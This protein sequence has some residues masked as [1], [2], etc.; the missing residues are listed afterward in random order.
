MPKLPL[1][2][3]KD[4]LKNE[5][6]ELRS[7]KTVRLLSTID[8][9]ENTKCSNVRLFTI[10][11]IEELEAVK[12]YTIEL[13]ARGFE[14]TSS[15]QI[16]PR[17]KHKLHIY[18]L[19]HYPFNHPK[20]GAPIRIIWLTPIFHPNISSGKEAGGKGIVCWRILQEWI[21]NFNLADIVIGI[22]DL[23]EKPNVDDAILLPETKEAAEWFRKHL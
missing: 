4:R 12:R 7:L 20:Y 10:N 13:Y 21:P 6:Q 23:V 1:P 3:L 18:V 15:G 16:I 5:E 14:R 22:K 17:E 2:L 9:C 11:G 19:R 8:Y